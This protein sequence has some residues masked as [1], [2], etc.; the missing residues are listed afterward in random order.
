VSK[1]DCAVVGGQFDYRPRFY[2]D[3]ARDCRVRT[4]G[5][6]VYSGLG[7]DPQEDRFHRR[8]RSQG[9]E[10][11]LPDFW[12]LKIITCSAL[13]S[14]LE[15]STSLMFGPTRSFSR[16]RACRGLPGWEYIP[17]LHKVYTSNWGEEKIGV[18]DLK[19]MKVVRRLPTADN[20]TGEG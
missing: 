8:P 2:V 12:M 14:A 4:A 7:S 20:P 13:I 1:L 16:Y 9:A 17:G 11:R 3:E 5:T 10:I 18:V 19:T 6:R 15:F